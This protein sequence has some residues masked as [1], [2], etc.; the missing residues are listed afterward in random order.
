MTKDYL[1]CEHTKTD[2]SKVYSCLDA[3][4]NT[5]LIVCQ[6]C[7]IHLQNYFVTQYL[8]SLVLS[9]LEDKGIA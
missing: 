6:I 3:G 5:Y 2:R 9:H 4:D 8:G 7:Y 1:Y